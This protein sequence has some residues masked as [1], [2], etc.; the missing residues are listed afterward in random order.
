[1]RGRLTLPP[2]PLPG[3]RGEQAD[4][5]IGRHLLDTAYLHQGGGQRARAD[6]LVDHDAAGQFGGGDDC[7]SRE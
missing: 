3:R 1:M 5:G 6:G 2:L 7:P 4:M